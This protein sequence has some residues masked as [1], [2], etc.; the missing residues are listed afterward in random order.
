MPAPFNCRQKKG[1][2]FNSEE[3][4]N[5]KPPNSPN[6]QKY[7]ETT[8]YL[9]IILWIIHKVTTIWK[10]NVKAQKILKFTESLKKNN[11]ILSHLNRKIGFSPSL[12]PTCFP[13]FFSFS[14]ERSSRL[15]FRPQ[16]GRVGTSVREH[17]WHGVPVI[18]PPFLFG[19]KKMKSH[20]FFMG[21]FCCCTLVF[22]AYI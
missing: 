5:G 6:C 10:N 21:F 13:L 20:H 16:D 22:L 11:K 8:F 15:Q 4:K 12:R 19:Y 1:Q 3:T 14:A 18:Y 2:T 7:V 9:R 17:Q